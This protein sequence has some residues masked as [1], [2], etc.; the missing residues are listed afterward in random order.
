MAKDRTR[1]AEV[2]QNPPSDDAADPA[3]E[4]ASEGRPSA[5]EYTSTGTTV[6]RARRGHAV[7]PSDSSLPVVTEDGVK[8]SAD[9]AKKV[10]EQ[11][12]DFAYIDKED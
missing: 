6:V 12:P 2:Q 9:N 7:V 11:Y 8:M 10:V 3:V 5:E 4:A 1:D